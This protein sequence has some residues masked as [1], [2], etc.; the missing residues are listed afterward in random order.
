MRTR[1]GLEAGRVRGIG[2]ELGKRRV[3]IAGRIT[4]Q[5]DETI[6]LLARESVR[7]R[8]RTAFPCCFQ[9]AV[10]SFAVHRDDGSCR[11][12]LDAIKWPFEYMSPEIPYG[13]THSLDTRQHG[14]AGFERCVLSDTAKANVCRATRDS[15]VEVPDSPAWHVMRPRW[16]LLEIA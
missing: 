13:S 4:D 11:H 1:W 9:P 3:N 14:A 7:A 6:L 8:E 15:N 16:C 2:H 10:V 5:S 12:Q